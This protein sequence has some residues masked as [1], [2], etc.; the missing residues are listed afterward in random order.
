MRNNTL[1]GEEGTIYVIYV[2][3]VLS[4]SL[5]RVALEKLLV[6]TFYKPEDDR[7]IVIIYEESPC[8][9][10]E[11]D[12]GAADAGLLGLPRDRQVLL[13]QRVSYST[14]GKGPDPVI[15]DLPDPDLDPTRNYLF[16]GK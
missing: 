9:V 7:L 3:E 16:I 2:H 11:P 10:E 4:V 6:H 14:S 8:W 15:F 1:I 12:D 5:Y 13:V